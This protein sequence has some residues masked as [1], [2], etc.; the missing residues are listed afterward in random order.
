[1]PLT[2]F[3]APPDDA[4]RTETVIQPDEII[5][6]V[7]IPSHPATM[8]SAYLKAMDRKVWAFALVG[9]A[10]AL[11]VNDGRISQ[12][13]LVLSGVAPVPWRADAAEQML[14]G[15]EPSAAL[16]AQVAEAALADATPLANNGYKVTLAQALIQQAL[17]NLTNGMNRART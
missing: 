5:T 11:D 1:L 4:R 13:R 7:R 17:S 10:A 16:F 3:F 9:V 8:R 2:E 12:A 6:A 15:A 14:I